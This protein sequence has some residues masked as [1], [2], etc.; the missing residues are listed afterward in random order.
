MLV[1]GVLNV[2]AVL[3]SVAT[4]LVLARMLPKA[5]LGKLVY[6]YASFGLLRL[7]MN[8]GLGTAISRD[9]A[10]S[11]ASAASWADVASH[12]DEGP[13]LGSKNLPA[14]IY[15]TAALRVTS[16]VC[17]AALMS[18]TSRAIGL[19]FWAHVTLAA[20]MASM[21][22]FSFGIIAGLLSRWRVG[23]MT[24]LQPVSYLGLIVGL[25]AVTQP[26]SEGVMGIYVASYAIMA[27]VGILLVAATGLLRL[28]ERSDLQFAHV[29]QTTAFAFP[30]YLTGVASQA[31][32]A[33][34]TG[35]LGWLRLFAA[36]AELGIAFSIATIPV[37]VSGP[38]ILTMFFPRA[39]CLSGQGHVDELGTEIRAML[40]WL[41]L[42]LIWVSV[43]LFA[44]AE[45]IVT[46]FFGQAYAPAARYLVVMSPLALIL[47]ALP[48]F[49]LSLVAVGRPW[50][51]LAGLIAQGVVLAATLLTA[52]GA[53]T[54]A[55]LSWSLL[56]SG[57]T[58]L[59]VQWSLVTLT[60]RAQMLPSKLLL[61][62]LGGLSA[63]MI[64][65]LGAIWAGTRLSPYHLAL[66]TTF[67]VVY[68]V[69]VV[70]RGNPHGG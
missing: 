34:A 46:T 20:V 8:F 40:K 49:T 66:M 39:S 55:R 15:S 6:F 25:A 59:V 47:G 19:P 36:S 9:V 14:I 65:R 44:F 23:V 7:L 13:H 56:L 60:L 50:R 18:W 17:A 38:T 51:A 12:A 22:D 5:E 33:L 64:L 41:V 57:L 67:T 69:A 11:Q 28:P 35:T 1:I 29:R 16:I 42:G 31:W 53:L 62:L 4:S 48:V 32:S 3:I 52:G 68:S 63:A 37:A 70:G 61:P 21:A 30:V 27:T 24:I 26:T 45:P 58:G 54:P 2:L 43:V 10:A